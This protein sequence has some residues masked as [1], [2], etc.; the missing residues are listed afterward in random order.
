MINFAFR[1]PTSD[2]RLAGFA[3]VALANFPLSDRLTQLI[4]NVGKFISFCVVNGIVDVI[5]PG[6]AGTRGNS[7]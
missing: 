1:F 3:R 6:A 7:G 5:L 4:P 2:F